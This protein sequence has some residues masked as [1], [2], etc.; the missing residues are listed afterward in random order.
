MCFI[1]TFKN[2]LIRINTAIR[3]ILTSPYGHAP[4]LSIFLKVPSCSMRP[5]YYA[6]SGILATTDLR[7]NEN[8]HHK[9]CGKFGSLCW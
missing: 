5:Y 4:Q 8:P 1:K 3:D 9:L 7:Y 2:I 6:S